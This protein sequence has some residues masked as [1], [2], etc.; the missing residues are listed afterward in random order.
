MSITI[1]EAQDLVLATGGMARLLVDG[2]PVPHIFVR[3][4]QKVMLL[5]WK[6]R[7]DGPRRQGLFE[8][9]V[10]DEVLGDETIDVAVATARR[11]PYE[12]AVTM[13]VVSFDVLEL[14]RPVALQPGGLG[15]VLMQ[16]KVGVFRNAQK[17]E[18]CKT[19]VL[20]LRCLDTKGNTV[21]D[22][23]CAATF[24]QHLLETRIPWIPD[25]ATIQLL[26]SVDSTTFADTGV[27]VPTTPALSIVATSPVLRCDDPSDFVVFCAMIGPSSLVET[28]WCLELLDETKVLSRLPV[29]MTPPRPEELAF[30]E[31]LATTNNYDALNIL[32]DDVTLD[33]PKLL[34]GGQQQNELEVRLICRTSSC[35]VQ[36]GTLL[37]S[38]EKYTVRNI[39]TS[40]TLHK[41]DAALLDPSADVLEVILTL[42]WRS[43]DQSIRVPLASGWIALNNDKNVCELTPFSQDV[44]AR[45]KIQTTL[46]QGKR[47][48][49]QNVNLVAF[50]PSAAAALLDDDVQRFALR[51]KGDAM[52]DDEMVEGLGFVKNRVTTLECGLASTVWHVDAYHERRWHLGDVVPNYLR[53]ERTV[54]ARAVG[55]FAHASKATITALFEMENGDIIESPA[56][57]KK[58]DDDVYF[59]TPENMFEP[60]AA[61]L[62]LKFNFGGTV[63]E[64]NPVL[65]EFLAYPDLLAITPRFVPRGIGDVRMTLTGGVFFKTDTISAFLFS[66]K[67]PCKSSDD[68]SRFATEATSAF[69]GKNE[70]EERGQRATLTAFAAAA[71]VRC[72]GGSTTAAAAGAA[73]A[74]C[75]SLETKNVESVADDVMEAVAALGGTPE[76]AMEAGATV[77]ETATRL[78]KGVKPELPRTQEIDDDLGAPAFHVMMQHKDLFAFGKRI[79][80]LAPAVEKIFPDSDSDEE[81]DEKT[82]VAGDDEYYLELGTSYET[83]QIV[84]CSVPD[85]PVERYQMALSRYIGHDAKVR[86]RSV[87]APVFIFTVGGIWPCIGDANGGTIVRITGRNFDKALSEGT[88]ENLLRALEEKKTKELIPRRKGSLTSKARRLSGTTT[89]PVRKKERT[90][91][92]IPTETT[93]NRAWIAFKLVSAATGRILSKTVV[94][95]IIR[96]FSQGEVTKW[97]SVGASIIAGMSGTL[98]LPTSNTD[99]AMSAEAQ[100]ASIH[101]SVNVGISAAERAA[102]FVAN[103]VVIEVKTPSCPATLLVNDKAFTASVEVSLAGPEGPFSSGADFDYVKTPVLSSVSSTTKNHVMVPGKSTLALRGRRLLVAK[104]LSVHLT[105]LARPAAKSNYSH[106]KIKV[107]DRIILPFEAQQSKDDDV[108]HVPLPYFHRRRYANRAPR[109][110]TIFARTAPGVQR[111][112]RKPSKITAKLVSN[113]SD[114]KAFHLWV[115]A[116][117]DECIPIVRVSPTTTKRDS[118]TLSKR[119]PSKSHDENGRRKSSSAS[120]PRSPTTTTTSSLRKKGSSFSRDEDCDLLVDQIQL[121]VSPNGQDWGTKALKK[122]GPPYSVTK[123]EPASGPSHGGTRL[124][125]KGDHF[126]T[127]CETCLVAFLCTG[128]ATTKRTSRTRRQT[129]ARLTVAQ[130]LFRDYPQNKFEVWDMQNAAARIQALGRGYV[131]RRLKG[132]GL[133]CVCVMGVIESARKITCVT[134]A[135]LSTGG[136]DVVISFD[137]TNFEWAPTPRLRQR[138][139]AETLVGLG[140]HPGD[141]TMSA[142]HF[143]L[144]DDVF[145]EEEQPEQNFEENRHRRRKALADTT[146]ITLHRARQLL[147]NAHQSPEEKVFDAKLHVEYSFYVA[148]RLG[149]LILLNPPFTDHLELLGSDFHGNIDVVVRFDATGPPFDVPGTVVD[150][151]TIT[152]DAP[153]QLENFTEVDVSVSLNRGVDF[154]ETVRYIVRKKP[155]LTEVRPSCGPRAGGTYI[156][157]KGYNFNPEED[158]ILVRFSLDANGHVGAKVCTVA[159]FVDGPTCLRVRLPFFERILRDME[160]HLLEKA[161][162]VNNDDSDSDEESP[163][164]RKK[165]KNT[166]TKLWLDVCVD[167]DRFTEKPLVFLLYGH[168]PCMK[169]TQPHVGSLAGGY[170]VRV[171]GDGFLNTN[172]LTVRIVPLPSEADL[173]QFAPQESQNGALLRQKQ[174]QR[175][176]RS[177]TTPTATTPSLQSPPRTSEKKKAP[178]FDEGNLVEAVLVGCQYHSETMISFAMPWLLGLKPGQFLVQASLNAKEFS[179]PHDRCLVELYSDSR[180]PITDVFPI[181]RGPSDVATSREATKQWRDIQASRHR[182]LAR[183]EYAARN[184]ARAAEIYEAAIA[185][186][187][188]PRPSMDAVL[189]ALS[190]ALGSSESVNLTAIVKSAKETEE[191]F[192]ANFP[193]PC[194]DNHPILNEDDT[195]LAP[196]NT[197][198]WSPWSLVSKLRK[199]AKTEDGRTVLTKIL[200]PAFEHLENPVPGVIRAGV[201]YGE[202]CEHLMLRLFPS[203]THL[204][205]LELWHLLDTG[206][207]GLVTLSDLFLR[208][209]KRPSSPTPGPGHYNGNALALRPSANTVGRTPMTLDAYDRPMIP[210]R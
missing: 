109:H 48:R 99:I 72:K 177:A 88:K 163:R 201:T 131:E 196:Q 7:G 156:D 43:A 195:S 132:P 174:R 121:E 138:R 53:V 71:A 2:P 30:V 135:S 165:K 69:Q 74:Y 79:D 96:R 134:P 149:D 9:K 207:T 123:I 117:P 33:I 85:V 98:I 14:L 188:A 108:V 63:F 158:D 57:V 189:K 140:M 119:K 128:T 111:T 97:S 197:D 143:S 103:D 54:E 182:P 166:I 93:T 125:I 64:T 178:N 152:V 73:A 27:E 10:P 24:R 42:K 13:E 101:G 114:G 39:R 144:H 168:V 4:R 25:C 115:H 162:V 28:E 51:I 92:P 161:V 190:E 142:A 153:S 16:L 194:L 22:V 70:D 78:L 17:L 106:H 183:N 75:M 11:G 124:S 200:K 120:K 49:A 122:L 12:T 136:V 6:K 147:R 40:L 154:T 86:H 81:E 107:L 37:N 181:V 15:G 113:T 19:L 110:V 67:E 167:K 62:T 80:K 59:P 169:F 104:T 175:R 18:A 52:K 179:D 76:A 210:L 130:S 83:D 94:Q 180:T 66:V 172:M 90:K 5:P 45:L 8:V 102:S 205:I 38:E 202:L 148:P 23:R 31:A 65:F 3:F 192:P 133:A 170:R 56:Y 146:D 137:G 50:R 187:H 150:D 44:A 32:L 112:T 87:P 116:G 58:E 199:F 55:S 173:V 36:L 82:C 203:S 209:K 26:V 145:A 68:I 204:D 1:V 118:T 184:N 89:T 160:S 127:E 164:R 176:P 139:M 35:L 151:E 208:L 46:V 34:R 191:P 47:R 20:L 100:F 198:T 61:R 126:P 159:A 141:A 95:G 21:K 29:V 206:K 60:Q 155:I 157:I 91:S 171:H 77:I 84:S 185:K 105:L 193:L 186:P 129:G 41:T